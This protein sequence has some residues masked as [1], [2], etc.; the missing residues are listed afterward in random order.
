MALATFLHLLKPARLQE[1]QVKRQYRS[2][3]QQL[4]ARMKSVFEEWLTLREVET[5][6]AQ[7]ANAAAVNRWELMRLAKSAEHLQPPRNLMNLHRDIHNAVIGAARACQLL[8]NGYRFHNSEA[9][10]DGQ[11]MLLETV[12]DINELVAQLQM[13]A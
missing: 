5:D 3:V 9:V 7:L 2:E 1:Q 11:A 8:A 12:A 4:A 10:C 13:R 6:N